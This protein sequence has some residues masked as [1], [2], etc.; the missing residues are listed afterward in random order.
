MM[1]M[2]MM[3]MVIMMMMMMV[4]LMTMIMTCKIMTCC[5]VALK[6][7]PRNAHYALHEFDAETT[8]GD[9]TSHSSSSLTRRTDE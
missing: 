9:G 2:I 4:M 1:M 7:E 3:M 8:G 5:A 6:R